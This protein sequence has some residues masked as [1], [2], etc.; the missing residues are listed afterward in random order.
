M[1]LVVQGPAMT[2]DQANHLAGLAG[3]TRIHKIK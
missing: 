2:A 1:N 3:S